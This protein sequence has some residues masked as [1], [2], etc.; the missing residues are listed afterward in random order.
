MS[1]YPQE[2]HEGAQMIQ[3]NLPDQNAI[4]DL[5]PRLEDLK[6]LEAFQTS[7][8]MGQAEVMK[9]CYN[10]IGRIPQTCCFL[11]SI[12][13]KGPI[14]RVG[15]GQ[16]GLRMK[17]GQIVGKLTPGLHLI[18]YC[19]EVVK[20][21]DI[22]SFIADT[23]TQTLITSDG[24]VIRVNSFAICR[25]I[26][27][28]VFAFLCEKPQSLLKVL[29]LTQ[30]ASIVSSNTV[31][32]FMTDRARWEEKSL[33]E[34]NQKAYD[35]GV[36]FELIEIQDMKLDSQLQVQMS[37]TAIAKQQAIGKRLIAQGELNS[38]KLYKKTADI[39]SKSKISQQL[40]YM[41]LIN[42]IAVNKG[43][44]IVL[45]D[46]IIGGWNKNMRIK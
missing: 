43:S 29:L 36:E 22:R 45:P 17:F 32:A 13:D 6:N 27:P 35:I 11:C 5:D 9:N 18:N 39:L 24:I 34:L 26:V 40:E 16:V 21:V 44:K 25:V 10:K 41:N 2:D 28:E 7:E 31:D 23:D 37:Q 15:T 19:S 30:I 38:A 4:L 14:V 46:N 33:R 1:D 3:P 8:Q 20:L 12:C 42:D